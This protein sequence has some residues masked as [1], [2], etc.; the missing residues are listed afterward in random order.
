MTLGK[1]IDVFSN[2]TVCIAPLGTEKSRHQKESFLVS[3]RL[4]SIGRAAKVCGAFRSYYVL[5]WE[6]KGNDNILWYFGDL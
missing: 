5:S 2:T 6:T 1:I 3:L 4:I